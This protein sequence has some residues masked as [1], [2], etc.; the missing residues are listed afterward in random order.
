MFAVFTW[1]RIITKVFESGA[2]RY[3]EEVFELLHFMDCYIEKIQ[4]ELKSVTSVVSWCE[5]V[6]VECFNTKYL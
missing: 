4:N 1:L 3:A 2:D 5:K 6:P